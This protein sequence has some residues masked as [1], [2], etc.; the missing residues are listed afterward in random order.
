MKQLL[1]LVSRAAA[2]LAL[3]T[4]GY[5]Y[6]TGA[7]GIRIVASQDGRSLLRIDP[8]SHR[9]GKLH[10]TCTAT[11]F[12][13]DDQTRGYRTVTTFTLRNPRAPDTALIANN[14]EYIITF[15]DWDPEIGRGPNVLV[16]YRGTGEFL[17]A[18][19]LEEI[20]TPEEMKP[21]EPPGGR[22]IGGWPRRWRSE[23]VQIIQHV[24]GAFVNIPWH[25][26]AKVRASRQLQ[27]SALKLTASFQRPSNAAPAK[28]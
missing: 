25:P 17:K 27:L 28:P 23:N 4:T 15:D 7:P 21:L 12:Q 18:W 1:R 14:A 26:D 8:P 5:G 13:L 9:D 19:R 22:F 2:A 10:A 16:V 20:I 24:N 3:V 6:L 11:V